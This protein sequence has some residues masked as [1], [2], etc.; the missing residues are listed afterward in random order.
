MSKV[1]EGVSVSSPEDRQ[2]KKNSIAYGVRLLVPVLAICKAEEN[3]M[4]EQRW[5][6]VS[7][8]GLR[9]QGYCQKIKLLAWAPWLGAEVKV[10]PGPG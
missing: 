1:T 6:E 4:G 5:G 7:P 2:R 8:S 3:R 10:G 9:A